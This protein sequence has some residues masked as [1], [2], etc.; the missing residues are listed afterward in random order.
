MLKPDVI[1]QNGQSSLISAA[2]FYSKKYGCNLLWHVASDS[3]V[4]SKRR[5]FLFRNPHK[6][7][8][9]K[10]FKYG[11]K[12]AHNIIVQTNYQKRLVKNLNSNAK[13]HLIKNFHPF[14]E[15]GSLKKK[16]QIIWV[17][18]FKILKQPE[19]FMDLSN[20]IN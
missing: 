16:N 8:D 6:F 12:R 7:L 1:Y 11:V 17:A 3:N 15:E 14:P 5:F 2:A 18:N 19:L 4:V 9:R 20:P 10:F 13:I